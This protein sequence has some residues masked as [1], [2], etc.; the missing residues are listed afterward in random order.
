MSGNTEVQQESIQPKRRIVTIITRLLIA[1]VD[2]YSVLL[3]LY[4]LLH[5]IT[6]DRLW[7]VALLILLA[8]HRRDR[9]RSK[10]KTAFQ[11]SQRST[12]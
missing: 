11:V 1:T 4:L 2:V 10:N 7:P 12:R 5:F 3:I 6:R 9:F 8:Y